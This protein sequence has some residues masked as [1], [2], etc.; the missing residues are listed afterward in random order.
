MANVLSLVLEFKADAGPL[1]AFGAKLQ[2]AMQRVEDYN[3]QI[4]NGTAAIS[5]R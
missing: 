1:E 3:K 2:S 4:Q 5:K